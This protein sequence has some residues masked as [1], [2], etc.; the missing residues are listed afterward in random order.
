MAI[1]FEVEDG[2]G[3]TTATSYMTVAELKQYWDNY[4]YD[5]SALS[6]SVLM[7]NLNKCT[8]VLDSTYNK[9]YPGYR[10]TSTQGLEWPRVEAYYID[11][12][13]IGYGVVPQELKD[14]LAELVYGVLVEGGTL[15]PLFKS[16]EKLIETEV[17][18]DVITEKKKYA[19][20]YVN[21]NKRDKFTA[22]QDALYRLIPNVSNTVGPF[23]TRV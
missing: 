18:V 12:W 4:G 19:E 20:P 9:K 15:Q 23:V 21:Q 3:I 10:N 13:F 6:D 7:Q 22:V 16:T 5:Y 14:G 8:R 17:T 1:Q 11:G 2:T